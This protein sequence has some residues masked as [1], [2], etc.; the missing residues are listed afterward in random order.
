MSI[1]ITI[2]SEFF[3]RRKRSETSNTVIIML[4]MCWL[5]YNIFIILIVYI[6][7]LQFLLLELSDIVFAFDSVPAV[8]GITRD[9]FIG[10]YY[11]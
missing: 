8:F 6:I 11:F 7:T 1:T 5:F 10:L 3:Y 2:R 4:N 9:P